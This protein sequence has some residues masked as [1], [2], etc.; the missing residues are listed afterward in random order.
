MSDPTERRI[1]D[2]Q[3]VG[4]RQRKTAQEE[5]EKRQP[6]ASKNERDRA[7]AAELRRKKEQAA[8][9]EQLRLLERQ[10]AEYETKSS[11]CSR[12]IR[13]LSATLKRLRERDEEDMRKESE[14]NSWWTFFTSPIYGRQVPETEEQK[15]QREF[16]RLQRLHTNNIKEK[17]I[18]QQEANAHNLKDRLQDVISKIA[19]VKRKIEDARLADEAR[20]QERLRREQEAKRRAEAQQERERQAKWKAWWEAESVRLRKEEDEKKRAEAQQE[21]ERQAKWKAEREAESA[22]LRKE[23]EAKRTARQARE[24]QAA[25]EAQRRARVA[26]EARNRRQQTA[27]AQ[28]QRGRGSGGYG[29]A[30]SATARASA[31]TQGICRH[32]AFWPK[33]QGASLCSNCNLVQNH[34]AFQ[35]PGCSKI[36][37]ATCR[38]ALRG[39]RRRK[40]PSSSKVD[41]EYSELQYDDW[42]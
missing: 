34:F 22:R 16:H 37:C 38:Q 31:S 10:K 19:E 13:N 4:I 8:L 39:E 41:V 33:I 36:A 11:E 24:A 18:I 28:A 23:E 3:W 25:E 20:M 9:V 7:A 32:N 42:D 15:Q 14:R 6:E 12:A 26:Q 5:S 29:Q 27:R 40:Y 21:R 30:Q 35:C 1:Y 17:D 2:L